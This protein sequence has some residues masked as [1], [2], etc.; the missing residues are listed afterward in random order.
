[1]CFAGV[2]VDRAFGFGVGFDEFG[3]CPDQRGNGRP[4][5]ESGL[6][7]QGSA[8][9]RAKKPHTDQRTDDPR[10]GKEVKEGQFLFDIGFVGKPPNAQ[11]Q[12]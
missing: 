8:F 3:R 12:K 6:R 9:D 1:M 10:P 4:A 5:N 7:R 11:D 2:A